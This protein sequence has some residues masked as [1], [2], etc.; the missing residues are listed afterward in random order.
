M[1]GQHFSK[2]L[3]GKVVHLELSGRDLDS[4]FDADIIKRFTSLRAFTLV[5][6]F[7]DGDDHNRINR[8][9]HIARFGHCLRYLAF[10][11]L[12]FSLVL[13]PC[14]LYMV[15]ITVEYL[16]IP[17]GFVS[18]SASLVRVSY[19]IGRLRIECCDNLLHLKL[20][21]L[22]ESVRDGPHCLKRILLNYLEHT[23]MVELQ[24]E[25]E[26]LEKSCTSSGVEFTYDYIFETFTSKVTYTKS[27]I[28]GELPQHLENWA[29]F[30]ESENF[31]ERDSV[32]ALSKP[33]IS[34]FH[35]DALTKTTSTT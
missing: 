28:D 26:L 19:R 10:V 32:A 2:G 25:L 33:D 27:S 22:L 14:S 29:E 7:G 11:G 4:V 1:S 13:N 3:C 16:T 34:C 18:D 8:F 5:Q 20:Y 31:D 9:N 6:D 24:A 21:N 12:D 35:L 23:T 15:P 17:C 30:I